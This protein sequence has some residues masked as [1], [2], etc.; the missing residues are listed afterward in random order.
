[1]VCVKPRRDR[2]RAPLVRHGPA[3]EHAHRF[4]QRQPVKGALDRCF[5]EH[6]FGRRSL[7]HAEPGAQRRD[8]TAG[9][10]MTLQQG[11]EAVPRAAHV[12]Q[13]GTETLLADHCRHG[14]EIGR[15]GVVH[16]RPRSV[17][18]PCARRAQQRCAHLLV[19]DL[20]I[21]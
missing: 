4:R 20:E 14:D 10:A 16:R 8:G 13:Q 11:G 7:G 2:L 5:R 9:V 12:R 21:W 17:Q 6:A 3:G 18:Q 19:G 1:M 15:K